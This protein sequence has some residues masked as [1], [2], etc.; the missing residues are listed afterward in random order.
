MAYTLT[1]LRD[2]I[3]SYTENAETTFLSNI[4][5]FIKSAEERVLV[6]VA[7]EDFRKNSTSSVT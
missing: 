2:A 4:E 7:L 1:S 6:N 5:N 3:K